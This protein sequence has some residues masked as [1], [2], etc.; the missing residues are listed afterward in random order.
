MTKSQIS[1]SLSLKAQ[2]LAQDLSIFYDSRLLHFPLIIVLRHC[3]DEVLLS[4]R[5][6]LYL[7][8]FAPQRTLV[9]GVEQLKKWS[10]HS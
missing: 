1:L 5:E 7:K 4:A 9:A 3:C 6:K 8:M 10:T 2:F